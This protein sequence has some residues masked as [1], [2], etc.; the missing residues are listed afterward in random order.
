M[1]IAPTEKAAAEGN[2]VCFF[3]RAELCHLQSCPGDS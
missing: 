2:K 1:R 3:A